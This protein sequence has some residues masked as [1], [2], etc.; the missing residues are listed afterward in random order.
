MK[1]A[2]LVG[3]T[4]LT[5]NL[6]L[7][8]LL[9]NNDYQKVVVYT[10]RTISKS[11]PKLEQRIIDFNLLDTAV[12]AEDVFCCLGTTIK[13]AGSK[14]AFEKVDHDYPL[15]I[16]KLQLQAGSRQFLTISAMGADEKSMI[17]YSRIKGK[18]ENE[19]KQLG[20]ESLYIFRPSFITGNR[21]EKRTGE[22]IG[23]IF[24]S[25]INPIMI[26]PL[27]K[28][29]AVAAL[30]IA[31]AMVHFASLNQTGNHTI[32]SDEIKKFE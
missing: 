5:G 17:F 19:L 11:H 14:P 6:L 21:K 16:A 12:P 4:G 27:K 15:K 30:A 20:Y 1:T 31:K 18:L 8:L 26:G 28:Y 10:R 25:I 23:L 24:M 2:L 7:D 22:Y 13:Q 29:K 9:D 32:L 3:A